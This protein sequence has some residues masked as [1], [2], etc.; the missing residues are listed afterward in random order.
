MMLVPAE[1]GCK[2]GVS[3]TSLL[4][5]YCGNNLCNNKFL[6]FTSPSMQHHNFFQA[7]PFKT[8]KSFKTVQLLA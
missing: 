1:K 7:K 3:T 2:G 5:F 6:C 4:S 8:F